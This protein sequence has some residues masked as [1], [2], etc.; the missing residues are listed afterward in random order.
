MPAGPARGERAGELLMKAF[1]DYPEKV[2]PLL[3][4]GRRRRRALCWYLRFALSYC[5]K[6]GEVFVAEPGGVALVLKSG[7]IFTYPRIIAAG[8]LLGPLR[9]G[10]AAF[11]R[12]MKNENFLGVIR[13]RHAAPGSWYVWF[14]GVDPASQRRGVGGN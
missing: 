6:Y 8:L 12:L 4:E 7:H 9:M 11:W 1:H 10:F 3:P 2:R 13:Q 14:V 5:L